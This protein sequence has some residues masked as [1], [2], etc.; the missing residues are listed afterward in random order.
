MTAFVTQSRT[1]P[2]FVPH[3]GAR[4]HPLVVLFEPLLAWEQRIRQRQRLGEM[5]DHML[6]DIGVSR[7]DAAMEAAKPFWRA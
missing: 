6:Q 5:D 7:S 4:K 2:W 3:G 1:A